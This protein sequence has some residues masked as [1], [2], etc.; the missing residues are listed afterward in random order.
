M[1]SPLLGKD[2]W[3]Q[4]SPLFRRDEGPASSEGEN[5]KTGAGGHQHGTKLVA[6]RV[7]DL[8]VPPSAADLLGR[9]LASDPVKCLVLSFLVDVLGTI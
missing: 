6:N 7:T 8:A 9:R 4:E 3:P 1:Q 5:G 2:Q